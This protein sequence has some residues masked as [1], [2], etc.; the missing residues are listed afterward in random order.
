MATKEYVVTVKKGIDWEEVHADLIE[1][2]TSREGLDPNIVPTRQV[3]VAKLR[4]NNTRSTHYL[5]EPSEAEGLKN[6]TRILDVQ[7]ESFATKQPSKIQTGDF[8]RSGSDSGNKINYGLALHTNS[9][10]IYNNSTSDPGLD[11]NYVLDGTGVDVVI[12]DTGIQGDHPEWQDAN[13]VSR[14]K[15]INWF[16]ESGVSGAHPQ[17]M[18]R[19][20][21]GHGTHVAS[22][23]AGKTF[24]WAKN[25]DIYIQRISF[26]DPSLQEGTDVMSA[27]DCFDTL[28]AWHNAKTNNR[29]TILNMS[30][31]N[32]AEIYTTSNPMQVND[33]PGCRIS[34]GTYRGST[35]GRTSR[36]QW[37][38]DYGFP[39]DASLFSGV[40]YLPFT[41]TSE[42]A[43][44]ESLIDAGVIVCVAA[45]N[46]D[47][48]IDIQSGNDY[49]NKIK[50]TANTSNGAI[51]PSFTNGETKEFTY[52]KA[53]L[54]APSTSSP[55]LLVGSINADSKSTTQERK[56]NYSA[57][58]PAVNIYAA[59]DKIVGA[60]ST[61][62]EG[63]YST[64]SY[65]PNSSFKQVS[66]QGT[67]QASPQMA[68]MAACLMQAH[69]DWA[70]I[71]VMNW[72]QNNAHNNLYST[73]LNNDS[74][75][76][77]SIRGSEQ[78]VAFFPL[79]GQKVYSISVS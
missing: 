13:G 25:A 1:D 3:A 41:V 6:D 79:K 72:F 19:D 53:G 49:D 70:P 12:I 50:I 39:A 42:I 35:H 11:Y 74:T 69:P 32:Y 28:L 33:Y 10:N 21:D 18:Y 27:A 73:G 68:G 47:V 48:K 56:A 58:G 51:H 17:N 59:G 22:V 30:W 7:D 43:S 66:T 8:S 60:C 77:D 14:L 36:L 24:G 71:Q 29:P 44:V 52:M 78:R 75:V 20:K 67:S 16:S 4:Q 40:V 62:H 34:G 37:Q 61:T 26:G 15:E 9:A 45:G 65:H 55:G 54:F 64:E 76:R 63:H 38:E 31:G 57:C 46:N 2:T 5:L 23:V